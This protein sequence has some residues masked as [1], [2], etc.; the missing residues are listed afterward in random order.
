M[1]SRRPTSGF[2]LEQ[3]YGV[4]LIAAAA[5]PALWVGYRV[6]RRLTRGTPK[7]PDPAKCLTWTNGQVLAFLEASHLSPQCIAAFKANDIDGSVLFQL[8][9]YH[10]SDMGVKKLK[11]RILFEKCIAAIRPAHLERE[12][13][14]STASHDSSDEEAPAPAKRPSHAEEK[15]AIT[16]LQV[17]RPASAEDRT[18]VMDAVVHKLEQIYERC[19]SDAFLQAE[20]AEQAQGIRTAKNEL[21]QILAITKSFPPQEVEHVMSL[22]Q[23]LTSMLDVVERGLAQRGTTNESAINA[24]GQAAL[25][26]LHAMLDGFLEALASAS[27]ADLPQ[28]DRER[29]AMNISSHVAKSIEVASVLPIAE[30][31]DL[32]AKCDLVLR[33]AR[34]LASGV[35][36]PAPRSPQA[37]AVE[38][39]S[40]QFLIRRV[41]AVFETLKSDQLL[42]MPAKD[43]N[44][45]LEKMR[46]E[47][48]SIERESHHLP[49]EEATVMAQVFMNV[50]QVLNQLAS[51]T[52]QEAEMSELQLQQTNLQSA[53]AR[54][55][56]PPKQENPVVRI[57]D[58]I[59]AVLEVLKKPEF[60]KASSEEQIRNCDVLTRRLQGLAQELQELPAPIQQAVTP[61]L[62][63]VSEL[64]GSVHKHASE[65]IASKAAAPQPAAKPR[66]TETKEHLHTLAKGS[67]EE[68]AS[69]VARLKEVYDF[70]SSEAFENAP[71]AVRAN[72][73]K[74]LLA[75]VNKVTALGHQLSPSEGNAIDELTAPLVKLL[76]HVSGARS[77]AAPAPQGLPQKKAAPQAAPAARSG[78]SSE[79]QTIVESLQQVFGVVNSERFQAAPAEA[80]RDIAGKLQS[81]VTAMVPHFKEL[82]EEERLT[83][84]KFVEPL[85]NLLQA[86]LRED[87][88]AAAAGDEAED[89]APEDE[90]EDNEAEEA[91][92]AESPEDQF[93]AFVMKLRSLMQV[94]GSDNFVKATRDRRL[95]VAA[96]LLQEIS[97]LQQEM[98][99][100]T[101]AQRQQ[102]QPTFTQLVSLI[103]QEVS[104]V[105]EV[106]EA[107]GAPFSENDEEEPEELDERQRRFRSAFD[108]IR[109]MRSRTLT[110]DELQDQLNLLDEI[111]GSGISSEEEIKIRTTFHKELERAIAKIKA[112]NGIPADDDEEDADEKEADATAEETTPVAEDDGVDQVVEAFGA[113]ARAMRSAK[114][115]ST[116]QLI[117]ITSMIEDTLQA[118]DQ[119][120][121]A[122]RRSPAAVKAVGDTLSMVQEL[123]RQLES[124]P[125]QPSEVENILR[126]ALEQ[127]K[128]FPPTTVGE[129]SQ[130]IEILDEMQEMQDNLT[131]ED[132]MAYQELQK[133]VLAR[134]KEMSLRPLPTEG[135]LSPNSSESG[136]KSPQYSTAVPPNTPALRGDNGDQ[137]PALVRDG[138]DEEDERPGSIPDE[139][140]VVARMLFQMI[141]KL[142][143]QRFTNQEL[144]AFEQILKRLASEPLH[145]EVAQVLSIADELVGVH[146]SQNVADDLKKARG[147]SASPPQAQPAP[148]ATKEAADEEAEELVDEEEGVPNGFVNE[149]TLLPRI[150]E[151]LALPDFVQ[152]TTLFEIKCISKIL[153]QLSLSRDVRSN[154]NLTDAVESAKV[155]FSQ[156]M[157]Q[158]SGS[159]KE[160]ASVLVPTILTGMDVED[161]NGHQLRQF[162][163]AGGEEQD[164][165]IVNETFLAEAFKN[166][167]DVAPVSDDVKATWEGRSRAI[168]FCVEQYP[169]GSEN[170]T[171][172]SELMMLHDTLDKRHGFDIIS[173]VDDKLS[174]EEARRLISDLVLEKPSRLLVYF[175]SPTP[176]S[177][178]PATKAFTFF[179]NTVLFHSDVLAMCE[180]IPSVVVLHDRSKALDVMASVDGKQSRSIS[181]ALTEGAAQV[182]N[183]SRC[184][185]FDGIFTPLVVEL[186][187]RDD[188]TGATL[189]PEDIIN[190]AITS[191]TARPIALGSSYTGD[192]SLTKGFWVNSEA[193]A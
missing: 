188:E 162:T 139:E 7:A 193:L 90:A 117:P 187:G 135:A 54:S 130:Y 142:Q 52:S 116:S 136:L 140:Q 96:M 184:W 131:R 13:S 18:K 57:S 103:R 16:P 32:K 158:Y 190:F 99:T 17:K 45:V 122:W 75:F 19:A 10:L 42:S 183:T 110:F 125:L 81:H 1:Q 11:D 100:L 102:V 97:T 151:R 175:H 124:Q 69:V 172:L 181:V 120:N 51:L 126:A 108:G 67:S 105:E 84:L 144:D 26:K 98:Q 9:S 78:P 145:S 66:A 159:P 165:Y 80:Q 114:I 93:G 38:P 166:Q 83:V 87:S 163:V 2:S 46:V 168:I 58:A 143:R 146:R 115:T 8:E 23:Q 132:L 28:A 111:D 134:H 178:A 56:A 153:H 59:K 76:E 12:R 173:V 3:P 164:E 191:L 65:S 50:K 34:A 104:P 189:C 127:L 72:Q 176:P 60:L 53:V 31:G 41:R 86:L 71:E 35:P 39:A 192:E 138:E 21:A 49:E 25:V 33:A 147:K 27:G 68:F 89:E 4:A 73:S 169:E 82:V 5:I 113:I 95:K 185:L 36:A 174:L 141:D 182:A 149:M 129:L 14:D 161:A 61:M 77:A 180:G 157:Q 137:P 64:V 133:A 94:I 109:L 152:T 101:P 91:E 62:V 170:N 121:I 43:R 30:Q 119:G 156:H 186:L 160:S 106:E 55:A 44:V 155:L 112:A 15:N 79:F 24:Q 148:V 37:K 20:P 88:T 123:Q 128:A 29:L 118:A 70:V 177:I 22:I 47:I 154:A 171:A 107:E 150:L 74:E 167:V 6:A 179:D 48:A 40:L 92:E 63:K 85:L